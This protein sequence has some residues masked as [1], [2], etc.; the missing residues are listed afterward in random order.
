LG[1]LK[2]LDV[3]ESLE[4][5]KIEA[6]ASVADLLLF[7]APRLAT[8]RKPLNVNLLKTRLEN[9]KIG[10]PFGLAGGLNFWIAGGLNFW[11]A[12]GLNPQN[13][14]EHVMQLR[15]QGVDVSSGVEDATG[16]KNEN[17]LRNFIAAAIGKE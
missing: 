5:A 14:A 2:A 10:R 12:G 17:A 13:V 6:F 15:P 4:V 11:I 9:S 16:Y 8:G 7:D 1:I 3:D